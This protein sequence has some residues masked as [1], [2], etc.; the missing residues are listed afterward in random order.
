MTRRMLVEVDADA[1]EHDHLGRA[2]A[3]YLAA[4]P[5]PLPKRVARLLREV[6]DEAFEAADELWTMEEEAP[7]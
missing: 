6:R 2:L 3:F 1:V 5:T 4:G 7:Q